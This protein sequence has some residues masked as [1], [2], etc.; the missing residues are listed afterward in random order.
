M[1][2]LLEL[3]IYRVWR[4]LIVMLIALVIIT[5]SS[6]ISLNVGMVSLSNALSESQLERRE[7]LAYRSKIWLQRA[8]DTGSQSKSLWLAIGLAAELL[9]DQ[10]AAQRVWQSKRESYHLFFA[11]AKL[12]WS[13]LNL[14]QA[15]K[16]LNRALIVK[17]DDVSVHAHFGKL[18]HDSGKYVEALPHLRFVTSTSNA[19]SESFAQLCNVYRSLGRLDEAV[20]TYVS[21][22]ESGRHNLH[23]Q[24]CM[25]KVYWDFGQYERSAYFFQQAIAQN[26]HDPVPHFW[27]SLVWNRLGNATAAILEAEEALHLAPGRIDYHDHLVN[28]YISVS[29]WSKA[30]EVVKLMVV[31]A[32]ERA[33]TKQYLEL[34]VQ[35]TRKSQ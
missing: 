25:G 33:K 14:A 7:Q 26:Q 20:A 11:A 32:P 5:M 2:S 31:L 10:Q 24:L 34:I 8:V 28:L 35:H 29:E 17:P 19:E 21:M 16:W 3:S 22:P 15:T 23:L 6:A 1:S 27:L 13:K 9:D 30:Q 4:W 12:E 18:Y